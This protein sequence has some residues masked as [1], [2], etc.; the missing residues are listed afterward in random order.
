MKNVIIAM[1]LALAPGQSKSLDI[2]FIDVEGGQSTLI[3]TPSGQAL[4]IDAGFAGTGGFSARAGDPATARDP[5]RILAVAKAAGVSKIDYFLSTHFHADHAGGVPELS[6]LIPI[7]AFID[8]GGVNADADKVAGTIAIH[9]A[10]AAVRKGKRHLE[11]KPGER[12]P[13]TGI[14]ATIVSSGGATLLAPLAGATP[15]ANAACVPPGVAAS[16]MTENPRSTG[17]LLQFGKFRFLDIGDLSDA[18]LFSLACPSDRIGP[19]D[20]YLV[21]HHG[22]ADASDPSLFAAIKPRVAI[23]N[24]G[25]I[26][27]GAAATF[28]TLRAAA[29]TE[30]WQLHTSAVTGAQNFADERI[31]NLTEATS[32]GIKISAYDDGS[33][34]V[35]NGRTGLTTRHPAR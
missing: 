10:Y 5:Q 20:V 28:K 21:S 12:I 19:V 15:G 13:L 8:H 2:Y 34:T 29:G 23:L 31:A 33:F 24:N 26:K 30:T 22:G 4:L 35:T 11:P 32:Y 3:V 18:P 1:L 27:G 25:S 7:D 17:V 16:E 9:E 6:Q 14:E